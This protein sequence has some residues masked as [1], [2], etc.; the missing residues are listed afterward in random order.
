M[1]TALCLDLMGTVIVDPYLEALRAGT[2][3]DVRAAHRVK[4]PHAWPDFEMARIDEATFV[5]RFFS[6]EA[7]EGLRFDAEAFHLVRRRGY[8]FLPGMAELLEDTEGVVRRYIASNYPVWIEELADTFELRRRTDG[9]VA[10]CHLGVRKPDPAFYTGLLE[11][12]GHAASECL[13]VDDRVDN[14]TAA[15]EVG[16]KAHLFTDA[17]DLRRRL[18]AEGLELPRP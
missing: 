6:P 8:A 14:C 17:D 18:D 7:A 15:E 11:R 16:L 13:F 10:S 5:A 9:I 12:I 1:L 2:G 3:M 4:D